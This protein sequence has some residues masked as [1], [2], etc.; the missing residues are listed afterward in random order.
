MKRKAFIVILSICLFSCISLGQERVTRRGGRG[1][2]LGRSAQGGTRPPEN[3]EQ[4]IRVLTP[5]E[6]A[7]NLNFY[8]MD[9]LYNP[10]AVLGWATE[11][12]EEKINRGMLAMSIGEGKVYLGWRLLKDDAENTAFNIYRSTEGGEPVKLNNQPLIKTTDFVDENALLDKTN[13]W[14]IKP[15]VDGK[16]LAASEQAELPSNA[17]VQAYKSIRLQENLR[18]NMA[19]VG[20]LNGDGVYD[21]VLKH[22]TGGGKDP[23][24]ISPN[25]GKVMYDGYD[26]KTGKFL[27][28]IDLGWNVD[29]GIWWTPMVVRDLDGDN[30]AEVCVRTSDYAET[31]EDMLP[32]GQ[33]GFLLDAPEYLAVYDGET[34]KLIDKVDWIELGTVQDWGDNT[35]N[36]AS[37]HMLAVAYLD[38]KTPAVLAV[39][40]IYGMMRIDAWTLKDKKLEKIWR[41]TNERAPFM[42]QGQGQHTVKTGDIDGDGCD[43]IINGSIAIDND[44]RTIWGTGLGHGDRS[45]MGDIDPDNPGWEILYIIEEPHPRNG[46]CLVDAR[47]GKILFGTDES[48]RDNELG[49]CMAADIDPAYPGLELTGGRFYYSCNGRRIESRVPPQGMM[50]WWDADMLK[51]FVSR[52]GLAKWQNGITVPIEGTRISGSVMQIAD[53]LGDWRE[54]LVTVSSGEL[55]I[56]STDIPAA[57]RRVCLMQDALYRNDVC[58]HTMGYTDRHYPMVSY[59][60]G[61]K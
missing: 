5:E 12:I 18:A 39:R 48:T 37:R 17:P 4:G 49:G 22:A 60:L 2:R 33:T 41:W 34:G 61:T 27:W 9:P 55:R 8:A 51:E 38:G 43:E 7:P 52:G 59:Y 53:I 54:E 36:R 28:R 57:D 42:Y 19:G 14:Y 47:T 20:D 6:I 25:S 30:K 23:G 35:G 32:S 13:S 15:V 44:G 26:G 50:A 58:H 40:G 21:F 3:N 46:F 16:E 29:N 45:Y 1:M 24:R 11:R 10:D 56:Y 31:R